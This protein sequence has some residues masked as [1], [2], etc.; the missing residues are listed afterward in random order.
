VIFPLFGVDM[1]DRGKSKPLTDHP[2]SG[3]IPPCRFR[4]HRVAEA[5]PKAASIAVMKTSH[6]RSAPALLR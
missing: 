3:K 2:V 4:Q 5:A 1:F 6:W